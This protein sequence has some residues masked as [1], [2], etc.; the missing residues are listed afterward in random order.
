MSVTLRGSGRRLDLAG[1]VCAVVYG[2]PSILL[3]YGRDQA[4]FDY[5]ARGLSLGATPYVDVF[6]TKPPA[7]FVV[8]ALAL[9]VFG[10]RQSSIR[11]L[12]VL[13]V[14]LAGWIIGKM[15]DRKGRAVRTRVRWGGLSALATSGIYFSCFDFWTS[16]QVELWEGIALAGALLVV[17][18]GRPGLR[19]AALSGALCGVAFLFKY[20]AVFAALAVCALAALRTMRAS[21]YL[22]AIAV[23]TT[24]GAGFLAAAGLGLLP[25]AAAPRGIE[26]LSALVAVTRQ[27]ARS[28][29]V[30]GPNPWL[31]FDYAG[32]YLI[33]YAAFAVGGGV[34]AFLRGCR[35]ELGHAR[36]IVVVLLAVIASVVVQQKFFAY[37]WGVVVPFVAAL[38]VWG[39]IQIAGARVARVFAIVAGVVLIGFA[40]PPREITNPATTYRAHTISVARYLA[41]DIDRGEYLAPFTGSFAFDYRRLEQIGDRLRL[42]S[43]AGDTMCVDAFE[44][45]LYTVS[46]LRCPSRFPWT[47]LL[48][49]AE[50]AEPY[51]SEWRRDYTVS[52]RRSPPTYLV[53][54]GESVVTASVKGRY[55]TAFLVDH[56]RVL[57]KRRRAH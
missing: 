35:R 24:F 2:L 36:A 38:F 10:P 16:A 14:L 29:L 43:K 18:R 56:Y 23:T 53:I 11:Y 47:H 44:P 33:M 26:A 54:T 9:R 46:G 25:I 17:H 30:V 42:S 55:E 41:G 27:Y 34:V 28:T 3:P 52:L 22:R 15:L 37:H 50:T 13:G 19:R 1:Y 45:V 39:A 21:G 31:E 20:P 57:E 4:L 12:E 5:V 7:I 40:F 51:G 8:Y 48:S 6:D 32:R 49:S